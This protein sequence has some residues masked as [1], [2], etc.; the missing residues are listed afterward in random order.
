[1]EADRGCVPG[2]TWMEYGFGKTPSSLYAAN[3][4]FLQLLCPSGALGL[5]DTIGRIQIGGLW[6]TTAD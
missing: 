6:R 2:G 1:M 5:E 4:D 3:A